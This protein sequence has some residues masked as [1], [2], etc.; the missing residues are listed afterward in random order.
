MLT[1]DPAPGTSR[2]KERTVD[3][4]VS[5]MDWPRRL[6]A[7]RLPVPPRSVA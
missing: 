4:A 1:I 7:D 3:V 5:V 2:P 6:P